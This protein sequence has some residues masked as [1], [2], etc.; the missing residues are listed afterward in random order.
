MLL[1]QTSDGRSE[2]L[3]QA[4]KLSR[5]YVVL[6][7]ALNRHCGK[8]QQKVTVERVHVH[9]GGQAVVGMVG[10]GGWGLTQNLRNNPTQSKS[11]MHLS[12]RCKARTRQGSRCQSPA[13]PN[14][15]C[16]LHGGKSPGAPE[17][18]TNAFKHGRYSAE[19][20]EA[21]RKIAALLRTMRTVVRASRQTDAL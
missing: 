21:R 10:A 4:N 2:N 17:G 12:R 18:N 9:S 15:R 6:L 8:G 5:T 20:I 3:N 7:D 1:A 11:P 14:G 19:T 16:R 13:M